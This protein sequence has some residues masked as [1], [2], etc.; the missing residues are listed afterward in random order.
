MISRWHVGNGEI[1]ALAVQQR[2]NER[3]AAA[4]AIEHG[5]HHPWRAYSGLT[6]YCANSPLLLAR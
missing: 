4:Q 6:I 3:D 2:G 5:A 1:E